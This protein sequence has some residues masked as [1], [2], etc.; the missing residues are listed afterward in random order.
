MPGHISLRPLAPSSPELNGVARVWTPMRSRSLSNRAY[1]DHDAIAAAIER[2]RGLL[3]PERLK[4]I[5]RT[6]RLERTH[7]CKPV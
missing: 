4:S 6:A 5:G 7:S 2:A 1:A 3:L